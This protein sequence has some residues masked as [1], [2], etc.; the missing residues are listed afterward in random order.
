MKLKLY[1]A[2]FICSSTLLGQTKINSKLYAKDLKAADIAF[3]AEDYLNAINLYRNVLAI[4]PNKEIAHL[5]SLISRLKLS[6]VPDSSFNHM[7]KLKNCTRPEVQF[8]F[9]KIYHLTSNFDE[10]IKCYTKYQSIAEKYRTITDYEIDYYTNCSKNAKQFI[11]KPHRSVIKNIGS[12]INTAY[13]E[14]VPLITPN[15]SILYFTS[16]REGSVGNLKDAYGSYEEDVDS[17]QK[18]SR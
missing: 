7:A 18:D 5:N 11:S 10:A 17:S 12:T 2:L 16:R 8:Y 4:D 15:E 3:E 13:G 6:Q 14:Y 1:I 9:G